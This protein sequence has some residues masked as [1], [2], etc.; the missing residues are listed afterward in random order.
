[1]TVSFPRGGCYGERMVATPAVRDAL[2]EARHDGSGLGS[3]G[4]FPSPSNEAR[5]CSRYLLDDWLRRAYEL[6]VERVVEL[7]KDRLQGA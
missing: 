1:M 3:A 4:V 2:R 6:A 7:K 5:P